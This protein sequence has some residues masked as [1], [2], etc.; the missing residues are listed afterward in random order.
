MQIL[1]YH[2]VIIVTFFFIVGMQLKCK[3]CIIY[4]CK[5]FVVFS[6]DFGT[7]IVQKSC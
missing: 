6:H 1:C 7:M 4:V 5:V 3:I 2:N